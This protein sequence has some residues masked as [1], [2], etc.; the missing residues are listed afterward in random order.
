MALNT[1]LFA[2]RNPNEDNTL[3]RL[4]VMVIGEYDKFVMICPQ[5]EG[6]AGFIIKLR[7]QG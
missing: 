2:Y 3:P 5:S 7:W 6:K 4:G 1:L